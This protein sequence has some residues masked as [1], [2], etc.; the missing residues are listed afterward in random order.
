MYGK[1]E[2]LA[3]VSKSCA[4]RD[5]DLFHQSPGHSQRKC[6]KVLGSPHCLQS[7]HKSFDVTPN[8]SACLNNRICPVIRSITV[9]IFFFLVRKDDVLSV[10]HIPATLFWLYQTRVRILHLE[11]ASLVKNSLTLS[12]KVEN[13]MHKLFRDGKSGREVPPNLITRYVTVS[14][15]PYRDQRER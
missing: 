15:H 4:L 9:D 1:T 14:R 2:Y 5:I 11:L 10:S 6:L 12:L 8:F 13:G 3:E 7:L